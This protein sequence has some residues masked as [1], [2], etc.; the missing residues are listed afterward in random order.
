MSFFQLCRVHSAILYKN[1][2]TQP[3]IFPIALDILIRPSMRNCTLMQNNKKLVPI[4]VGPNTSYHIIIHHESKIYL[5]HL[6]VGL[7]YWSTAQ[8]FVPRKGSNLDWYRSLRP[9]AWH[10]A[11]SPICA[12]ERA[13]ALRSALPRLPRLFLVLATRMSLWLIAATRLRRPRS[14]RTGSVAGNPKLCVGPG[15]CECNVSEFRR[16]GN[17]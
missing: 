12:K 3:L 10:P 14:N 13:V 2:A 1:K 8:P 16:G 6:K 17:R 11:S 4:N 7:D 5:V 9:V 15:G